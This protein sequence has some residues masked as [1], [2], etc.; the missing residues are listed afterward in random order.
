MRLFLAGALFVLAIEMIGI[1]I[2]GYVTMQIGAL[3]K[4]KEESGEAPSVMSAL[5][6]QP[7]P[8][9]GEEANED[10]EEENDGPVESPAE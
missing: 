2:L 9:D 3:A 6:L 7:S 1:L 10:E 8:R 5:G 4:W